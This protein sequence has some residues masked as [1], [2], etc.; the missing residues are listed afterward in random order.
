M[1]DNL[2]YVDLWKKQSE[3]FWRTVY[4][5]PFIGIAI[6]AGWYGLETQEQ[7]TLSQYLLVAGIL[8][9]LVQMAILYRMAQYL[10]AFRNAA[11]TLIPSVSPAFLG[12]T[13]YRIGVAV[14]VILIALF[15]L[16]LCVDVKSKEASG[17]SSETQHQPAT[18]NKKIQ[19]TAE[20]GG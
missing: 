1:T 4:S 8:I 3:L 15:S 17:A 2:H 19:P 14:P 13:G 12:L 6:F 10:N 9:M 7:Q 5:V 16:M 20:S 11:D 18:T